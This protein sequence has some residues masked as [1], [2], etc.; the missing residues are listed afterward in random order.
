MREPP[1]DRSWIELETRREVINVM[2]I[3]MGVYT[4][5]AAIVGIVLIVR[6]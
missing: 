3:V 1:P 2:A 4:I 6:M 5:C